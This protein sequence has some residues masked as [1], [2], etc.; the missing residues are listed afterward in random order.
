MLPALSTTVMEPYSA[1]ERPDRV[2][3][4][5]YRGRISRAWR[6]GNEPSLDAVLS[7]I[8]TIEEDTRSHDLLEPVG[9]LLPYELMGE[10]AIEG[11]RA[12]SSCCPGRGAANYR[13]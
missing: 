2:K 6:N 9:L 7:P 5:H 13:Y 3:I 4:D 1:P 8:Q 12:Y 11:Y 10:A